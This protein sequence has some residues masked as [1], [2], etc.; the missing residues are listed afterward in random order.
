MSS[1]SVFTSKAIASLRF[2]AQ[3][4]RYDTA[5][6]G[7]ISRHVP[8]SFP[9]D[10]REYL[11]IVV[12]SVCKF[13]IATAITRCMGEILMPRPEGYATINGD[14]KGLPATSNPSP[15]ENINGSDFR[16]YQM[17]GENKKVSNNA[18]APK[19]S[20]LVTA[21]AKGFCLVRLLRQC[22]LIRSR[23]KKTPELKADSPMGRLCGK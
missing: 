9:C 6:I 12:G 10:S 13:E 3:Y 11:S 4:R 20:N 5:E 16:E 8:F 15:H 18:T 21:P 17:S 1:A 22:R 7:F 19:R 14:N 2:N 23:R